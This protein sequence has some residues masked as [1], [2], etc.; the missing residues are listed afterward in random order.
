MLTPEVYQLPHAIKWVASGAR[1]VA[2]LSGLPVECASAPERFI[3]GA[4]HLGMRA[5]WAAV[6]RHEGVE[7]DYFENLVIEDPADTQE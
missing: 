2:E 6:F 5:T 1:A 4:R 7:T 3:A